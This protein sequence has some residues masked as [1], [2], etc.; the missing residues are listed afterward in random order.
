VAQPVAWITLSL[1]GLTWYRLHATSAITILFAMSAGCIANWIRNR[2]YHCFVDGPIFLIA[3]STFL[4][5]TLGII[6]FPSSAIWVPLFTI[7]LISFWLEC[8]VPGNVSDGPEQVCTRL[9]SCR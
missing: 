7:V 3:G 9:L 1:I 2:T 8:E 6:Q 4:L 5:R